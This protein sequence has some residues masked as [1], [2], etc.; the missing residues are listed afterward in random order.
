MAIATR[1]DPEE[2]GDLHVDAADA[3]RRKRTPLVPDSKPSMLEIDGEETLPPI[4][5]VK[6]RFRPVSIRN[7]AS[8]TMKLGQLGLDQDPAIDEADGEG[9]DERQHHAHPDVRA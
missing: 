8:V 4:S 6:P 1:D 2:H 3:E 9:D 5:R 7:G